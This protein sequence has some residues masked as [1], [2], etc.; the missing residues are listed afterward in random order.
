MNTSL[1]LLAAVALVSPSLAAAQ[2][3]FG[4]GPPRELPAVI[5]Y[6]RPDFRGPALVLHPGDQIDNLAQLTFP[7]GSRVNDRVVSVEI[8]G[9]ASVLLYE[10]ARFRGHV[11]RTTD[12]IRNLGHHFLPDSPQRWSGV[13]SSLRVDAE[14]RGRPAPPMTPARAQSHVTAIYRTLLERE[15]DPRGL[16]HYSLLLTTQGWT[17]AMVEDAIR[18]SDE[19][20]EVHA[21]RL[22]TQAYREVLRRDPDPEGLA[23]YQRIVLQRGWGLEQLRRTLRSSEEF[24]QLAWHR[25]SG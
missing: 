23:N 18:A 17:P 3:A 24:R 5:V 22:V 13:V 9:R 11:L 12:S 20:R 21:A 10:H 1:R 6:G 7:D 4:F 14:P 2:P 25:G 15:P 8:V 16:R 19:F